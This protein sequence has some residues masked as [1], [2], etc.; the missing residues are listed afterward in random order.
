MPTVTLTVDFINCADTEEY[1]QYGFLANIFLGD[2]VHVIARRIGVS[3]FM[4]MT[5]YSYDC[6]TRKY[7]KV[8]LGTVADSV[9]NSLVS[10]RQLASGSITG[11]KLA[12][13]SVGA[14]QI[15]NGSVGSLQIGLA[16]SQSAHIQNAAITA[17]ISDRRKSV[18]RT[19]R[20]RPLPPRRSRR[21][22]DRVRAHWH[23]GNRYGEYQRRGDYGG[24]NRGCYDHLCENR[25]RAN[26]NGAYHDAADH[27][28]KIG[29]AAI[30]TAN[31][32]DAAINTAHIKDAAITN[33]KIGGAAIDT[34]NIRD[35]AI[36]TAKIL[37]LE[38]YQSQDCRP[39]RGF[40]E[41]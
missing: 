3:V 32:R 8:T 4:R 39:C 28:R 19:Y 36:V 14:G 11:A 6:L 18:W 10:A 31:I 12:M 38:H 15:V 7:T 9:E 23:G 16:Q 24:Q 41:D 20:T 37:D 25:R 27:Q 17:R 34:A 29:E 21:S 40:R 13:N 26:P 2:A 5:Q 22:R 30:D 33:A 35:A 1:R